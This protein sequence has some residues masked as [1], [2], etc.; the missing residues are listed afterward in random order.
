MK[1]IIKAIALA[2]VVML[3]GTACGFVSVDPDQQAVVV[4][5]YIVI[6]ADRTI[7]GCIPPGETQNEW[8]NDVYRYP[9][10]QISWDAT[11][12]E[13]SERGP[14]K[15][16]SNAS[17]PAEL[18]VP[19]IVTMS[20]TTDCDLLMAFHRDF[21][22]KYHGWLNDDGTTS[23]GWIQLL[24]YVVGQPL[25]N[26]LV[27]LAQKYPWRQIWN[28]EK[29]RMEFQTELQNGLEHASAQR[30]KGQAFFTDFQVLVQKP[31]PVDQALKDAIA[32]EQNAVAKANATKAEAVAQAE[33]AK[34]KAEADLTAKSAEVKVAEAE[35]TKRAAEIKGFPSVE[36]YLKYLAIENGINP[37]Q[38]V[39]VPG[40]PTTGK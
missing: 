40:M 16:V 14:Y 9:A 5:D 30:T 17:A 19:V 24:N 12:V 4:N 20:L 7:D 28:D 8:S 37:Y 21:G 39:I 13:G 38:P 22:T 34:T 29:V 35:A 15:G 10:R 32:S 2:S 23:P 33:A 11:G 18:Y 3:A 31:D 25:E 36:D 6:P 27:K 26:T 1:K